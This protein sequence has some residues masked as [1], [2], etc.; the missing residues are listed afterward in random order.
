MAVTGPT[1]TQHPDKVLAGPHRPYDPSDLLPAPGLVWA[2][3]FDVDGAAEPWPSDQALTLTTVDGWIWAHFNLADARSH[4]WIASQSAL[5]EEAREVLTSV[6]DHP[7]LHAEGSC[8]FGV[9]SDLVRD[10]KGPTDEIGKLRIAVT[11]HLVVSARRHSLQGADATRAALL[12]GL[13]LPRPATL[14]HAIISH[15]ADGFDEIVERMTNDLDV[16][17]DHILLEVIRDE[18][19]RLVRVRHAAVR[20]HRPLAG[21]RR[22]V[23]RL[24]RRRPD[25]QGSPLQADGTI[26]AQRL[27]AVDHDLSAVQERARLMQ[28]EIGAKIAAETSRQ[29]FTLSILTALFVPATLVTGL[30]GMNVKGL[31]FSEAEGGFWWAFASGVLASAAVCFVLWRRGV[32]RRGSGR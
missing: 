16:I 25:G 29:L 19:R 24:H 1:F 6:D 31:P 15:A 32:L 17:E 9:L 23:H 10:L 13:R 4:A 20:L 12:R 7:Q 27:E 2:F 30:F 22:V 26:L 8:V 28:D 3:R 5:P 11:E 18:R 14:L 21:L